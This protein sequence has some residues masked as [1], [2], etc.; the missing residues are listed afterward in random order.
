MAQARQ[1][2]PTCRNATARSSTVQLRPPDS[3]NTGAGAV[4]ARPSTRRCNGTAGMHRGCTEHYITKPSSGGKQCPPPPP[5]RASL[6]PPLHAQ[7]GSAIVSVRWVAHQE[8]L[9]GAIPLPRGW[10]RV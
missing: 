5:P 4:S 1:H 7:S 3:R 10:E 2:N 9:R 6:A 8:G